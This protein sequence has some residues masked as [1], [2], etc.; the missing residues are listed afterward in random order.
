MWK[1]TSAQISTDAST[2]SSSYVV[3]P[4]RFDFIQFISLSTFFCCSL[5][6]IWAIEERQKTVGNI[7]ATLQLNNLVCAETASIKSKL[8]E[9]FTFSTSSKPR[10]KFRM[11]LF[12]SF[13]AF[14][15]HLFSVRV[16]WKSIE[17]FSREWNQ[18]KSFSVEQIKMNGQENNERKRK[19]CS[20]TKNKKKK[21]VYSLSNDFEYKMQIE[22]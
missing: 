18:T 11:I 4:L 1:Y 16:K 6:L 13:L 10:T 19:K 3:F 8:F 22:K 7:R 21:I 12:F 15:F 14:H 20:W 17:C 5:V 2:F 9:I